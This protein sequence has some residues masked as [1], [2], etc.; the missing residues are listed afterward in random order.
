MAEPW[1]T[2]QLIAGTA[3]QCPLC[4]AYVQRT[5]TGNLADGMR[6]HYRV[7]HPGEAVPRG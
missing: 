2:D 6:A 1:R 4:C 3:R 7:V 5:Q